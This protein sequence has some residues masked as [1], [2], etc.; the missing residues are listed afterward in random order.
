MKEGI[1]QEFNCIK[2]LHK[3]AFVISEGNTFISPF[4]TSEVS[5]ALYVK[6][7]LSLS[8]MF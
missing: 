2:V 4:V 1:S 7:S 5:S 6:H 3:L 8:Q